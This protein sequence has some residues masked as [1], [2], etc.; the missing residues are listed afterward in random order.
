RG[1]GIDVIVVVLY[2]AVI[3][4][5][6][7]NAE[8]HRTNIGVGSSP[9]DLPGTA[10]RNRRRSAWLGMFDVLAP[11]DSGLRQDLCVAVKRCQNSGLR[12]FGID[13]SQLKTKSNPA[14]L[15]SRNREVVYLTGLIN[16]WKTAD[17]YA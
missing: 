5:V 16:G 3:R 1:I 12:E 14:R 6:S 8:T 17:L 9:S 7:R 15:S 11:A 13:G 2:T 4:R 10:A